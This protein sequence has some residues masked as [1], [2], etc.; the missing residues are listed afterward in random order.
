MQPSRQHCIYTRIAS[1]A[2]L[3]FLLTAARTHAEELSITSS[4]PGATVE[5]D[6]M[7]AGTTPYKTDYPG[8]YFHK[9]HAAFS[10]RLEHSMTVRVS[11]DGYVT[12]Q[13]TLTNGPF[14]WDAITGRRRGNY[15]LLKSNHFEIKLDVISLGNGRPAETIGREGPMRPAPVAA[16]HSEDDGAGSATGSA[17]ITSDPP[18][19]DIYV[20]GKF[21]GQTPST[22][23]LVSGLHHIEVKTQGKQAW[24]RDLDVLKDS[25]LTLHAVFAAQP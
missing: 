11:K 17:A 18:G 25:Q 7:V 15:F 10:T 6:G 23:H 8:G 13:I 21:V 20:D 4:P 14:E 22:I 9:T 2:L 16:A 1:L 19:A 3:A 12:Q 5:I 24:E